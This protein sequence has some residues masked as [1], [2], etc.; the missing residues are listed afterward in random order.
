L[1]YLIWLGSRIEL[2]ASFHSGS[3]GTEWIGR[4]LDP[5]MGF[6]YQ[7]SVP[8]SLNLWSYHKE[9]RKESNPIMSGNWPLF[10]K[11][12]ASV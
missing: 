5:R 1:T 9:L 12:I 8:V 11:N 3:N 10:R 4:K 2:K 7:F 6:W